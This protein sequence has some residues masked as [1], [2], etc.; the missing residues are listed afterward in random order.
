MPPS[1]SSYSN[2][3]YN[4]KCLDIIRSLWKSWKMNNQFQSSLKPLTLCLGLVGI[5]FNFRSNRSALKCILGLII[6]GANFGLNGPRGIDI[7]QLKFMEDINLFES[8]FTYLQFNPFSIVKL[9]KIISE[10]IFFCYVPFIHFVFIA[11]VLMDPNWKKLIG[12]LEKIQLE[13]KL[14]DSFHLKCRLHCLIALF[15]L[16]AVSRL[17]NWSHFGCNNWTNKCDSG[18]SSF[19]VDLWS[20][21]QF[22]RLR[23]RMGVF[24]DAAKELSQQ[25]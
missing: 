22:I 14:S 12:L 7:S 25:F 8:P 15:S 5:P 2:D 4:T 6:I 13:M 19:W 16:L 3:I 11:T 24:K 20:V 1:S 9:V 23:R 21:W 10:M 18:R 17:Y